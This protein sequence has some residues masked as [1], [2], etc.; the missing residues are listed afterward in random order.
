MRLDVKALEVLDP[1]SRYGGPM[2]D[3]A[4]T[5]WQ[6]ILGAGMDRPGPVGMLRGMLPA[7][8]LVGPAQGK[9]RTCG[10]RAAV[11][12]RILGIFL[13]SDVIFRT[14]LAPAARV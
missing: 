1:P 12:V 2:R 11:S 13:S 4:A 10:V 9:N 6:R 3:V 8:N 7:W 14:H 5:G